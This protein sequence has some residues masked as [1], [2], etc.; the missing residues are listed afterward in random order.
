LI[1]I[2]KDIHKI[3]FRTFM[4]FNPGIPQSSDIP[5][6]SQAQILTNFNQTNSVFGINHI[7]FNNSTV[8]N[9]GKHKHVSMIEQGSDPVTAANEVALYSKDVSSVSQLFLRREANGTVI[10]MTGQNPTIAQSGSTF[11]P[12]GIVMKWGFTGVIADNS[13][14]TFASAFPTNC[15]SVQL[16][17]IDPSATTRILNVKTASLTTANFQVRANGA[18]SA[19]YIAIGN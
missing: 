4:S 15:W 18:V 11:L 10:Q 6:Q 17:I 8:A 7:E 19:F 13:T 14:V 16:T 2:L 12:G 9:R 3:F 5:A 1:D